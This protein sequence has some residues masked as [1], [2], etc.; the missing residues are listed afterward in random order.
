MPFLEDMLVPW[1]VSY[2]I[3][4]YEWQHCL[5]HT[6]TAPRR[7]SGFWP[8]MKKSLGDPNNSSIRKFCTLRTTGSC[9]GGVWMCIAG[10][11]DLQTISFEIPW[12]LGHRTKLPPYFSSDIFFRKHLQPS[13]MQFYQSM[14]CSRVIHHIVLFIHSAVSTNIPFGSVSILLGDQNTCPHQKKISKSCFKG[15]C[16][17]TWRRLTAHNYDIWYMYPNSIK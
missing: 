8:A 1:R 10:V 5:Q 17:S 7:S 13:G 16:I 14:F 15:R 11:W 4:F 6:L 9:Y 3:L 12:F 2:S